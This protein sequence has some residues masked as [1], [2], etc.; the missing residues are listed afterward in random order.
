M[1]QCVGTNQR[2]GERCKR[3]AT[4]GTS[5]CSYHDPAK[6][7]ARRS[8]R[9]RQREVAR[10][11]GPLSLKSKQ[12]STRTWNDFRQLFAEGTGWGRCGCLFALDVSRPASRGRS[13]AQ[14]RDA[15]H[16]KMRDLVE[17]GRSRGVLIYDGQL[18]V[19]WCQFVPRDEVR[20]KDRA[21]AGADWFITCFVV[22]PRYR[23]HGVTALALR[24]A[25]QAIGRIGGGIVE[26]IGTA[27][28]PGEPPR[29]AR[30]DAYIDGDVVF[31]DGI[32]RMHFRFEVDGVG[33]VTA[34][35]RSERSMHG[36]PLGGT[37][38][39]FAQAGFSPTEVLPR[40]SRKFAE[41]MPDRI[42]M[43]RS[44]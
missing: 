19:G 3:P 13:W 33:P 2:T 18:P 17:Q 40:P 16:E 37:V 44:V 43:R 1:A 11:T 27:M 29:S 34:S 23:G 15:S 22:D 21:A 14:Q 20:L 12:L 24:A 32:A 9:A 4:Q 25:V 38:H 35:Y 6:A 8:M 26:G 31:S 30:K 41:F 10:K 39:L 28:V 7:A 36:A 5:T 42:V